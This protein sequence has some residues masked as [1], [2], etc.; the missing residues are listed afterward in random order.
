MKYLFLFL[1]LSLSLHAET[2]IDP[3][4]DNYD[5]ETLILKLVDDQQWDPARFVFNKEKTKYL[6][7]KPADYHLIQGLLSIHDNQI[8]GAI[9][10]LENSLNIK[11]SALALEKLLPLYANTK[12]WDQGFDRLHKFQKDRLG[13]KLTSEIEFLQKA[14]LQPSYL[15]RSLEWTETYLSQSFDFQ[16]LKFQTEILTKNKILNQ[17][18]LNVENALYKNKIKSAE[19]ALTL[20]EIFLS[21]GFDVEIHRFLESACL[22]FPKSDLI[23]L[24]L[25]QVLFKK[26]QLFSALNLLSEIKTDDGLI[27]VQLELMNLM[28]VKSYSLF[29]RMQ[30]QDSEMHLK[31]W[32]VYLINNE[33]WSLLYSTHPRFSGSEKWANDEFN[34]AL[35]Y[36]SQLM[37][38]SN[39]AEIFVH[40][41]R[42]PQ[43]SDKKAK[44][45]QSLTQ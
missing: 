30:L 32:F 20:A 1:Y 24:N 17:T 7:Q 33:D 42:S 23:K 35:A 9:E 18:T 31:N 34:Y 43:L 16:L 25:A 26:D 6:K 11:Y 44:L 19:E 38:D 4:Y 13:Q 45:L 41:V 12:N 2:V 14:S 40:R 28:Q 39:Q 27:N 22:N 37:A 5:G 8:D 3:R 29:H 15:A 10:S 36:S 21:Q